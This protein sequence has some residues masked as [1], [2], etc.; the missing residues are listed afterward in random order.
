[1]RRYDGGLPE[2]NLLAVPDSLLTVAGL[3]VVVIIL[4]LVVMSLRSGRPGGGRNFDVSPPHSGQ[5]DDR[6]PH[7]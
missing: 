6:K 7:D 3:A 4:V 2:V 1:M 5:P